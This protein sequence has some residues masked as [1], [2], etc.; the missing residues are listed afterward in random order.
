LK[1]VPIVIKPELTP[2][3]AAACWP[4]EPQPAADTATTAAAAAKSAALKSAADD[5]PRP[6]RR[7]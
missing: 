3:D 6:E 1:L 2:L 7:A 4:D 5:L